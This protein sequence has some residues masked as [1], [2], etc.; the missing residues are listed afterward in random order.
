MTNLKRKAQ[1]TITRV[2]STLDMSNGRNKHVQ[3]KATAIDLVDIAKYS[4]A[5]SRLAIEDTILTQ[6]SARLSS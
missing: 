2:I 6:A 5:Y 1:T 4:T 3:V